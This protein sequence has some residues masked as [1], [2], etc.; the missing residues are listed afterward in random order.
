MSDNFSIIAKVGG[1]IIALTLVF[2]GVL[3]LRVEAVSGGLF[4]L[5]IGLVVFI[6]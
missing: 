6:F 1:I 4:L 2:A 3:M 5:L